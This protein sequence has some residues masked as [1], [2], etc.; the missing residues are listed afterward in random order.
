MCIDEM[1]IE[2]PCSI[3]DIQNHPKQ[4][5]CPQRKGNFLK[6]PMGNNRHEFLY[7]IRSSLSAATARTNSNKTKPADPA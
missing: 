5:N 4:S 2:I 7:G 3:F 6:R 1:N